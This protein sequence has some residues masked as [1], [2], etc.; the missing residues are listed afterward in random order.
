[1][2]RKHTAQCRTG[3]QLKVINLTDQ[4]LGQMSNCFPCYILSCLRVKY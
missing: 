2:A 1:M 4:I 3:C